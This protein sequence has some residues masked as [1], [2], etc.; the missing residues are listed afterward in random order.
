M[1]LKQFI[2]E[3]DVEMSNAVINFQMLKEA[4]KVLGVKF[5]SEITEYLTKYGYLGYKY[6]ELYGMNT[7]QGL[8]SDMIKQTLYLHQYF[9]ATF[10]LIA[11]ENQGD[12]DYYL[13]NADDEVFEFDAELNELTSKNLTFFEYVL[14]RFKN[15]ADY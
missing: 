12:G 4:E 8:D 11:I 6:V 1:N 2:S 10:G 15:A 7:R 5:G 9:P 3:N 14:N 13:V